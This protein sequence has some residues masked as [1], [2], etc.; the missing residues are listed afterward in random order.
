MHTALLSDVS[1]VADRHV[2]AICVCNWARGRKYEH[3]F[4]YLMVS[5]NSVR[6][7]TVTPTAVTKCALMQSFRAIRVLKC[8][9]ATI[10][11]HV[12][13]VSLLNTVSDEV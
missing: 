1:L 4:Q 2:F 13:A 5:F 3:S 7:D 9:S 8:G 12:V 6:R 10:Q 11:A